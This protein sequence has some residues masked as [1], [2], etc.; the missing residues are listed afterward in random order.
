MTLEARDS[1]GLNYQTL[2]MDAKLV[3]S[4]FSVRHESFRS[5]VARLITS[6]VASCATRVLTSSLWR[7]PGYELLIPGS[8][9][10]TCQ[11]AA[12]ACEDAGFQVRGPSMPGDRPRAYPGIRRGLGQAGPTALLA[13]KPRVGGAAPAAH[14]S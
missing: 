6:L 5:N 7:L 10:A 8:V 2:I 3:R 9:V 1:L 11:L 13:A 12:R 4:R 14:P